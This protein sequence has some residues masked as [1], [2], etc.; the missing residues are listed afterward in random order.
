MKPLQH[1]IHKHTH[2]LRCP[3]PEMLY[4]PVM[5]AYKKIMETT[6][7]MEGMRVC[8]EGLGLKLDFCSFSLSLAVGLFVH[9]KPFMTNSSFLCLFSLSSWQHYRGLSI[10]AD[11]NTANPTQT[12]PIRRQHRSRRLMKKFGCRL[13]GCLCAFSRQR[14]IS[15][16]QIGIVSA[17]L[18]LHFKH[19]FCLYLK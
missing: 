10:K 14:L 5:E 17:S 8:T 1:S 3:H 15:S 16:K 7:V 2:T 9:P 13:G 18:H 19:I 11:T 12:H 4:K 6:L